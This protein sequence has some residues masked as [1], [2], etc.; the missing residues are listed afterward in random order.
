LPTK[1]LG[2]GDDEDRALRP[3]VARFGDDVPGGAR[4]QQAA[5]EPLPTARDVV[6]DGRRGEGASGE[7]Y[8]AAPAEPGGA[9]QRAQQ[10]HRPPVGPVGALL[11]D[12]RLAAV[13]AQPLRDP[14]G[15]AALAVGGGGALEGGQ[16]ADHALELG[17]QGGGVGGGGHRRATI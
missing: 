5:A 3:A 7:G 13:L 11:L 12:A 1:R 16:V 14:L 9:G 10:P 15:G 17:A 4:G 2:A 8:G 6:G